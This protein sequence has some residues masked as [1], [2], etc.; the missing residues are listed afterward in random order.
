MPELKFPQLNQITVSGRI[1]RDPELKTVGNDG[2]AM[3]KTVGNDGIAMIKTVG[4]DGIAMIKTCLAIDDGF[5]EKRKS[6]FVDFA[7]FGKTAEI[8]HPHLRKG[9]P[10]IVTGRLT[11]EEWE[12]KDGSGKR[13]K[14]VIIADRVHVLTWPDDGA[15]YNHTTQTEKAPPVTAQDVPDDDIPF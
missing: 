9:T 11:V 10:V 3:I 15:G 8:T 1:V 12:S 6:Y 5:G 2:I 14:A 7:A 13:S 4:N